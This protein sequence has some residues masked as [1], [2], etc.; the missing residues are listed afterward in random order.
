MKHIEDDLILGFYILWTEIKENGKVELYQAQILDKIKDG[1]YLITMFNYMG[2]PNG[3]KIITLD[4][5]IDKDADLYNVTD[6]DMFIRNY[7]YKLKRI[8]NKTKT[9]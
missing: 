1:Y 7:E 5:L 8:T 3:I 6:R 9:V 4:W 2:D